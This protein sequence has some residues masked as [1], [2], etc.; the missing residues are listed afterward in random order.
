MAKERTSY[1]KAFEKLSDEQK[2]TLQK[3]IA[4]HREKGR[5]EAAVQSKH[6]TLDKIKRVKLLDKS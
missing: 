4:S 6:I 1:E 2:E 3:V 5:P